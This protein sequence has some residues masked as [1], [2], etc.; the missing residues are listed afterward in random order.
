MGIEFEF[1]RLRLAHNIYKFLFT[2]KI[3]LYLVSLN[4]KLVKVKHET[5]LT[6]KT[7]HNYLRVNIAKKL[8]FTK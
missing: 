4:I 5:M 8:T 3:S 1:V 6:T 2:F 7:N